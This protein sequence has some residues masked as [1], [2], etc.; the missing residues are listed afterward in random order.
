MSIFFVNS[1]LLAAILLSADIILNSLDP[2]QDL[3][4]VCPNLDPKLFDTLIVPELIFENL[5]NFEESH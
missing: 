5:N 4:S 3:H 1:A 2:D